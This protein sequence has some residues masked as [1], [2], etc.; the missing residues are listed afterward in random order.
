MRN[1]GDDK[2]D[3]VAKDS[4]AAVKWFHKAAKQGHKFS[5]LLRLEFGVE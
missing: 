4:V 3:G 2:G 5:L 1:K